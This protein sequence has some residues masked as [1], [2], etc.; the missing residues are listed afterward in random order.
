[1]IELRNDHAEAY[2]QRGLL[3]LEITDPQKA[4]ID[5]RRASQYYIGKGDLDR[6]RQTRDLSL[7]IHFNQSADAS[8]SETIKTT[9]KEEQKLEPV[10]VNNLF[11]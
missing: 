7:E 11:G 1:M 6:Y 5:L 2:H 8:I 3:Y 9:N 10:A 4:I